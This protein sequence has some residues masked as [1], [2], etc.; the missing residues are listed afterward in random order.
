MPPL[1]AFGVAIT[2]LGLLGMVLSVMLP[3]PAAGRF[4]DRLFNAGYGLFTLALTYWLAISAAAFLA[5]SH[6]HG[7]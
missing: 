3:V 5:A 4:G 6:I 2:V 7:V 1:I